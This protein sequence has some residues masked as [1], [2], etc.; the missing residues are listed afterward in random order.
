M[1][2]LTVEITKDFTS[3]R[4]LDSEGNYLFDSEGVALYAEEHAVSGLEVTM[5]VI[6]TTVSS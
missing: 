5:S 6:C 2:C 1:G 4:L 3:A